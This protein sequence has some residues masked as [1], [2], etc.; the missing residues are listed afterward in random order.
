MGK[1]EILFLLRNA[2]CVIGTA[3][4]L[5]TSKILAT[6]LPSLK[7]LATNLILD[8]EFKTQVGRACKNPYI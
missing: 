8:D 4:L 2:Y 7:T 1:S 5:K 6:K 3:L